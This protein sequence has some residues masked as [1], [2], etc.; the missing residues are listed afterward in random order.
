MAIARQKTETVGNTYSNLIDCER[1]WFIHIH[2]YV[3][4]TDGFQTV[5]HKYI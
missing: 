5:T 4:V 1:D 2:H 3:I